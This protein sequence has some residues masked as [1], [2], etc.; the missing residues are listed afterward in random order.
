[1]EARLAIDD[2]ADELDMVMNIGRFL[3]G[4]Y[5]YVQRDIEAIVAE[6]KKR[7]VLVKVILETALLSAEQ[8]AKACELAIA[9]GADFVKTSTGFSS[10]GAT[11]AAV[12]LMV[13]SCAGRAL[14]KAS[15]G[16]RDWCSAVDF[17]K[18]GARRLGVGCAAQILDE[19]PES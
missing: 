4:D 8:I 10:A 9:A 1:L 19:A 14:V 6:A 15:G 3:S 13:R 16:I 2:G 5:T 11:S 7:G 12:E 17:L 18:L